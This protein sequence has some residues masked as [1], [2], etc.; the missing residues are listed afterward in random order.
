MEGFLVTAAAGTQKTHIDNRLKGRPQHDSDCTGKAGFHNRIPE[1][2]HHTTLVR[3]LISPATAF[4]DGEALKGQHWALLGGGRSF[5]ECQRGR[6]D[7]HWKECVLCLSAGRILG[8]LLQDYDETCV[9]T[10]SRSEAFYA[11]IASRTTA[12][13]DPPPKDVLHLPVMLLGCL[14]GPLVLW[15][16]VEKPT[17]YCSIN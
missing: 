16:P 13:L 6:L 15:G 3:L 2:N 9:A 1:V 4:I 14:G 7:L 12:S 8:S 10:S 11:N 5:P 17:R